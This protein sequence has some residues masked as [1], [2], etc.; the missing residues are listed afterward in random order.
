M[1]RITTINEA[2][3]AIKQRRFTVQAEYTGTDVPENEVEAYEE[4][5]YYLIKDADEDKL[6][7]AFTFCLFAGCKEEDVTPEELL[8]YIGSSAYSDYDLSL[9]RVIIR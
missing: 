2:M 7:D 6:N 8:R 5:A 9:E 3:E 1:D 4:R